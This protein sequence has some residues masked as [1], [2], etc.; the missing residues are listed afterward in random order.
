MR[1]AV[2]ISL[3]SLALGIAASP[4]SAWWDEGHMQIAYLAYKRMSNPV[5]DKADALL[6]LNKDYAKWTAGASDE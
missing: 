5:R 6:R 2:S 3:L 4:A 1:R